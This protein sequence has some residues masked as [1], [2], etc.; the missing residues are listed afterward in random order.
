MFKVLHYGETNVGRERKNNEDSYRVAPHAGVF[1]VCDGM[2]GHASGELASQIAADT[3]VRYLVTD[4]YRAD[5]RWPLESLSQPSEETRALD[6]AIRA[7]NHEVFAAAQAN[8]LHKGMGTTVVAVLAGPQRLGL[9][10]VG[11]SRIYRFRAG[12]FDQLTDDHSLL[13]H[14]IRT[15]PM[16]AQ[17]IRTFAGKNVIV[18]AVG[19]RDA[20]EPEL[21]VQEYLAGD[22]YL[23]CTDGLC[24]MVDD[25]VIAEVM[26]GAADNLEAAGQRLVQLALDGGGRDNV[27]VLLLQVVEADP[28]A[29]WELDAA[30]ADTPQDLP[31]LR[32]GDSMASLFDD[33]TAVSV[34]VPG[35]PQRPASE[36]TQPVPPLPLMVDERTQPV[37]PLRPE[38]FANRPGVPLGLAPSDEHTE[39]IPTHAA[40]DAVKAAIEAARLAKEAAAAPST[41]VVT[42]ANVDVTAETERELPIPTD[43]FSVDSLTAPS[44]PPE[45][46]AVPVPV[47]P[48]AGAGR[49]KSKK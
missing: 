5:F 7:A 12:E 38:D 29:T 6:A 35:A 11:D 41:Q 14:Y 2:G 23:L 47:Q 4:R 45:A 46:V 32:P 22:I 43:D 28:P 15:R 31:A 49:G 48:P 25:D 21:Q 10:H 27:T 16:S 20:V 44:G 33:D 24:D 8:P 17:Q 40:R 30:M 36:I 19:L 34:R 3:L 18:R 9:G 13:N 37:Q 42:Q 39:R 26:A 1:V